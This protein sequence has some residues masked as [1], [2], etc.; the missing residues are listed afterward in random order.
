[1]EGAGVTM[2][3]SQNGNRGLQTLKGIKQDY[4]WWWFSNEQKALL[5]FHV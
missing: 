1:M 2:A 4:P 3:V 5:D